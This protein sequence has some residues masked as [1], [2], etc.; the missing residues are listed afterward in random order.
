MRTR[1]CVREAPFLLFGRPFFTPKQAVAT[2]PPSL[3]LRSHSS[4]WRSYACGT[5]RNAAMKQPTEP[6][7]RRDVVLLNIGLVCANLLWSGL[8]VIL[9]VPLRR[10]ANPGEPHICCSSWCLSLRRAP[11][12]HCLPDAPDGSGVLCLYRETV[13]FVA[14]AGVAQHYEGCVG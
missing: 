4:D 11:A 8:H 2:S 14:L 9:S 13:G 1:S 6:L 12:T 3:I 10:G 5:V 7:T